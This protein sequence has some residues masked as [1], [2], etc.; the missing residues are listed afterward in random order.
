MLYYSDAATRKYYGRPTEKLK[1]NGRPNR[2][3]DKKT[4]FDKFF[5]MYN[6]YT[7]DLLFFH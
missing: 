7:A 5:P 1:I 2:D 6:R 4:Y 3:L